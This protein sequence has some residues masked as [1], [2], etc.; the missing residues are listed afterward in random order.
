[1]EVFLRGVIAP[2][3]L[4]G[5]I[6]RIAFETYAPLS[7]LPSSRRQ[8]RHA[9]GR[10]S[11][12][13][14]ADRS[15]KF[16]W[17][18]CGIVESLV[19]SLGGSILNLIGLFKRTWRSFIELM[20]HLEL[21]AIHGVG[22]ETTDL[23]LCAKRNVIVT[24]TP[25]LFD[26]VAD[27]AIGLALASCRKVAEGD[28]FVRA[29]KWEHT[30]LPLDRKFTGMRAGVVGLGRIGRAVANRLEAFKTDIGYTD[31][32]IREPRY[33]AYPDALSLAAEPDILFL[34]A[35]G[36]PIGANPPIIGREV[37][38]ALGPR[39]TFY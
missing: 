36:G 24:V 28:R 2:C 32:N 23:A 10:D 8:A 21:C 26:D 19:H 35:T 30:S 14:R 18:R 39:G 25:V 29:G 38:E 6:N 11:A 9:I 37:L 17:V 33:R 3:V 12:N 5:P 20:P 31:P 15:E 27:L 34:C 22:L 13:P 1:V 7:S 4:D 16:D